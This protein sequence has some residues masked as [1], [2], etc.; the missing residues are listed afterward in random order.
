VEASERFA[1]G[2]ISAAALEEAQAGARAVSAQTQWLACWAAT[3]AAGADAWQAA[4]WTSA[5]AAEAQAEA[6]ARW[7]LRE[8]GGKGPA[9]R[10]ASAVWEEARAAQCNLLRDILGNPF[11]RATVPPSWLQ[12]KNGR[13]VREAR[14]I[15]NDRR[16]DGL[17]RLARMLEAAGCDEV[18][19]LSHCRR[20]RGHVRGCWVLDLLLGKRV[21]RSKEGDRLG[22]WPHRG[23]SLPGQ[24]IGPQRWY[25]PPSSALLRCVS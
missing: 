15:Y 12:W 4:L 22:A 5:W 2:L 21:I 24:L 11:Q 20:P 10:L 18:D 13:V 8:A 7:L 1:D 19:I 9:E 23:A 17:P 25:P 3:E 14:T 16:F 6:A